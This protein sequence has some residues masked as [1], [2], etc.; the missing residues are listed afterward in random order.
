MATLM[1]S[2]PYAGLDRRGRFERRDGMDRRNLIRYEAFGSD[3]RVEQQ[4]R[5]LEDAVWLSKMPLK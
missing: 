1:S 2:K 4:Q 5:R 3:R